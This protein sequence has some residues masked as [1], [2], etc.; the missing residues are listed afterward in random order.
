MNIRKLTLA[1]IIALAASSATFAKPL[2]LAEVVSPTTSPIIRVQ[3]FGSTDVTVSKATL[4]TGDLSETG[5][6]FMNPSIDVSSN[7]K[8]VAIKNGDCY[9]IKLNSAT[10]QK[11]GGE[12][13]DSRTEF[14]F[15]VSYARGTNSGI[16]VVT[17]TLENLQ[18]HTQFDVEFRTSLI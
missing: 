2:E 14:D 3:T 5:L 4:D 8:I 6:L 11:S 12:F 7:F 18:T 16:E 15:D 1:A 13:N 17:V 10:L 9:D